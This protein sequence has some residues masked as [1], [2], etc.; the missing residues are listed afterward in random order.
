MNYE[1]EE[2]R[3]KIEKKDDGKVA[4]ISLNRP[5]KMNALD[6]AMFRYGKEKEKKKEK[7][8][9]KRKYEKEKI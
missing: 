1:I 3:V 6:M 9:E 5:D 8:R 7:K 4:V 2:E